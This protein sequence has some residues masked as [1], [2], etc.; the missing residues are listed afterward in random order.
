MASQRESRHYEGGGTSLLQ[1][2]LDTLTP[3]SG[4]QETATVTHRR[5]ATQVVKKPRPRLGTP[6]SPGRAATTYHNEAGVRRAIQTFLR[7]YRCCIA[8]NFAVLATLVMVGLATIVFIHNAELSTAVGVLKSEWGNMSELSATVDALKREVDSMTITMDSLERDLGIERNR[9]AA[10]EK[11]LQEMSKATGP[12]GPP[13][14]KGSMGPPGPKGPMGLAGIHKAEVSTAVGVLKSEWGNMSELSAT[15]DA[16]KREVNS[17]F[18]T[19]DSSERDLGVERNRSAALE[20]RLQEMSKTTG[21]PGP[22]GQKG[23]MGPPGPKGLMGL[24]GQKAKGNHGAGWDPWGRLVVRDPWGRLVVRDPWGRLV[25][26]DPWGRVV[27]GDPWGRLVVRDPWGWLDKRE[28]YRR[29]GEP[30]HRGL[31]GTK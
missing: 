16:L 11:R 15:V 26:R 28:L 9:S 12:S 24:A 25:L 7:A 19:V 1:T 20:K 8:A 14:Q 29:P 22:P 31:S 18:I 6:H 30:L 27:V 17:I 3:V 4:R 10:L 13:G 2:G 21:P 23:S 5:A